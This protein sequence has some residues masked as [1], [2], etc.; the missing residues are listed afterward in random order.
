MPPKSP[1]TPD[2]TPD[3]T[4]AS[5]PGPLRAAVVVAFSGVPDGLV[6]PRDFAIGDVVEG[7]LARVALAEGWATPAE[8]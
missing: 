5:P 8:A 2:P 4:P 7:D 1:P 6:L 3:P